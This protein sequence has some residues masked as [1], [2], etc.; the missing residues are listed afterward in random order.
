M[1][2]FHDDISKMLAECGPIEE[3]EKKDYTVD[4]HLKLRVRDVEDEY[5]AQNYIEEFVSCGLNSITESDDEDDDHYRLE[6]ATAD[7]KTFTEVS[8]DD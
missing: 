7:W 4:I 8:P 3:S 5:E 1:S 6:C 2:N